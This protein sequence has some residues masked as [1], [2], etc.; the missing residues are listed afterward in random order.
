MKHPNLTPKYAILNKF[1][2]GYALPEP[3]YNAVQKHRP[4][5]SSVW[6]CGIRIGSDLYT[7]EFKYHTKKAAM[8]ACA[9]V[10]LDDLNKKIN[11]CYSVCLTCNSVTPF[12][13]SLAVSP[14]MIQLTTLMNIPRAS[15]PCTKYGHSM[16]ALQSTLQTFKDC[17]MR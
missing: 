4:L 1:C 9:Q 2:K 11:S 15:L 3:Q 10:A 6:G 5:L 8:N 12:C 17:G 7:V 13:F 16:K 14:K